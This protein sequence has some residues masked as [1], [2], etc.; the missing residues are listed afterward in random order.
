MCGAS[1]GQWQER[2]MSR[3]CGGDGS[4]PSAGTVDGRKVCASAWL[5]GCDI[6]AHQVAEMLAVGVDST[7]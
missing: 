2:S 3:R 7:S 6:F 1:P 5:E 4:T